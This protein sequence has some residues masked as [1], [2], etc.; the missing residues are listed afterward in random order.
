MNSDLKITLTF[1]GQKELN[2]LIKKFNEGKMTYAE[3]NKLAKEYGNSVKN[4]FIP[5]TKEAAIAAGNLTKI[6]NE[7]SRAKKELLSDDGKIRDSYFK[8]GE[9]LRRFYREQRVGDRTMRE[10]TQAVSGLGAMLGDSGLGKII[11]TTTQ[12]FQE[13]EFATNGLGIALKSAGGAAAGFGTSLIAVGGIIA[14]IAAAIGGLIYLHDEEKKR[15][16]ALND[17]IL[18]NLELRKEIGAATSGELK[19]AYGKEIDRKIIELAKISRK[20]GLWDAFI[21]TVTNPFASS[22]EIGLMAQKRSGETATAEEL[23]LQ[24]EIIELKKKIIALDKEEA[25]EKKKIADATKKTREEEELR[26]MKLF[27]AGIH[28]RNLLFD[29]AQKK[30]GMGRVLQ[31]IGGTQSYG[32]GRV[33]PEG[34]KDK[35]FGTGLEVIQNSLEK[36]KDKMDD[37]AEYSKNAIQSLSN[38]I[39]SNLSNAFKRAFDTGKFSF[40]DF[41]STIVSLFLSYGLDLGIGALFKN[42]FHFAGGGTGNTSP[43]SAGVVAA[44]EGMSSNLMLAPVVQVVPITDNKGLAVRVEVGNRVNRK[45]RL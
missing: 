12:R 3:L 38:S 30:T 42:V 11:G 25:E 7:Q 5:G 34:L 33:L 18:K 39:Q 32:I 22:A 4:N 16:E 10:A 19:A 44:Q 43:M 13:M 40:K 29:A 37:F 26:A 1:A 45:I 23:K 31:M 2:D 21:T 24:N 6:L 9:E 17:A 15:I 27:E 36:G 14:G 41:F 35:K 28:T 8:I 20:P